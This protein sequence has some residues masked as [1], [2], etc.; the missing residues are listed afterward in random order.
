VRRSGSTQRELPH[1]R[2]DEQRLTA[3][4]IELAR[5][6]GRSQGRRA[7]APGGL[8]NQRQAGRAYLATWG[9][10]VL[11]KQPK[12]G[13]LWPA[14]G[15]YIRLRPEHR[16]QVWSYNDFVDDRTHDGRKYR[17]LNVLDELQP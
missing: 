17:M 11:H 14:D 7:P 13:T 2:G 9:L 16:N 15:S 8:D 1:G 10:K 3:D 5:Q 6:Y 12:R 4:I